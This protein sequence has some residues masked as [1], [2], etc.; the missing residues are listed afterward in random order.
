[1]LNIERE[2]MEEKETTT[3]TSE[4]PPEPNRQPST[5][6]P[7]GY[8][9]VVLIAALVG[10]IASTV[11][12]GLYDRFYAQKVVAVDLKGFIQRQRDMLVEGKIEEQGLRDSFDRMEAVFDRIPANHVVILKEV[13]L[14]NGRDLQLEP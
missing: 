1:M 8:L 11:A 2:N 7:P 12:V 3:P 4:A 9:A 5:L 10:S 6:S 14:R 13:V